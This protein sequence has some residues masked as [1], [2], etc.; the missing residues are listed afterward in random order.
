MLTS[1]ATKAVTRLL[2][3]LPKERLSRTLG[4]L[5]NLDAHALSLD[6]VLRTAIDAYC[7]AYHVDLSDAE[8]P[9]EGFHSFDAF[10]TRTLRPGA[11]P[12]DADPNTVV[13]PCDG[14]V[15]G[16]GRLGVDTQL[17]VKGQHYS[18]AALLEDTQ[19]AKR[20]EGGWYALVYLSP[21][22]Y[23][24]VHVPVDGEVVRVRHIDGDLFP[25]NQPG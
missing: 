10:F 15:A 19:A 13:S 16:T 22:D 3:V 5:S 12:I 25:V 8:I 6:W 14:K 18:L 20:Y 21:S 7:R 2:D 11:R 17:F 23:H 1:Q 24:R 4:K 9:A